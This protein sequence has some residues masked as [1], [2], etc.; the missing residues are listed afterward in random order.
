MEPEH[1][2]VLIVGAG[3]SGVG[4]ACHLQAR[5]PRQDLRDP[6]G[7]R[8]HR[9]HLGPVP[10]PRHPLGLGHVHARLQLPPLGGRQGDRRRPCDPQLRPRD[11]RAT[12]AWTRRSASTTGWFARSGPRRRP[13]GRV[14]AE[15][16]DTGETRRAHLLLPVRRHR[17][18]P[19]RRG[20]PAALRGHRAL[21]RRRSST[22][23]TGRRTSTTP[24]SAWW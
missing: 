24:A 1:V 22:R 20:L 15:R 2:D 18:L 6:R 14:D 8:R 12:T 3:L 10:L 5:L 17:L 13:A 4:T 19:L 16:T 21:P 7:A 11:R 9:R 23:S